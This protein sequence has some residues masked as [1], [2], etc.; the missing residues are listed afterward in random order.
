MRGRIEEK[1]APMA[2][3]VTDHSYG[4]EQ[5]RTEPPSAGGAYP[6]ERE[7]IRLDNDRDL[8]RMG[9]WALSLGG[10]GVAVSITFL[11]IGGILPGAL[12]GVVSLL[13][14]LGGALALM[15]VAH[16]QG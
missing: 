2:N 6:R 4:E 7:N 14:A 13:I 5:D 10:L 8:S 1:G 9:F 11:M 16:H 15:L 12:V 3:V